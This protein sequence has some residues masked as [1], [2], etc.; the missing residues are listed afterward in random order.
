MGFER[1]LPK[2]RG[3]QGEAPAGFEEVDQ[4]CFGKNIGEAANAG[5]I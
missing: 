5:F 2:V 3:V 1:R 4:A